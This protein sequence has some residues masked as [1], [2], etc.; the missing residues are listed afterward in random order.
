MELVHHDVLESIRR[1]IYQTTRIVALD[2]AK[3][4]IALTRIVS[5]NKQIAKVLVPN[6]AT[7]R[8]QGLVED[9]FAVSDKKQPRFSAEL[10]CHSG[11]IKRSN[12]RFTS[13]S[14]SDHEVA[15]L[16]LD[17]AFSSD[18]VENLFLE[19][20]RTKIEVNRSARICRNVAF[21]LN[22]L[23]QSG[24]SLL[25]ESLE[26]VVLPISLKSSCDFIP[27]IRQF[28]LADLRSPFE[29]FRQRCVRQV[30]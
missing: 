21:P 23:T 3:Q 13:A 24:N 12:H 1:F 28:V 27:K 30:R 6:D 2:R 15:M 29:A 9:F 17:L 26:L 25:I 11:V 20:K 16:V 14:R 8:R 19:W 7:K 5:I 22:R 18:D 10:L 4:V